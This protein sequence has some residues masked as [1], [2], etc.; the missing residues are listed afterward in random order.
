M[1]DQTS[2]PVAIIL[3]S[4]GSRGD[5]LLFRYP[6]IGPQTAENTV[7]KSV[8]NPYAVRLADDQQVEKKRPGSCL[9]K[10][11]L[12]GF[13]DDLLAAILATKSELCGQK[14]ELKINDLRFIGHPTLMH[15]GSKGQV[16]PKSEGPSMILFNIVFALKAAASI[17]VIQ[18]YHDFSKRLAIAL[19]HEEHRCGY[20][21]HEAK[22]MLG[23]VDEVAALPEADFDSQSP[24]SLMLNKSELARDLKHVYLSL[25]SNGDPEQ[26]NKCLEVLRPYHAMLLLDDAN[27][28]IAE[29]SPDMSPAL[30]RVFRVTTPLKSLRDLGADADL[31]LRQVFYLVSHLVYW[32]KATIIYPLCETNVYVLSPNASLQVNATLASRFVEHFPGMS[33]HAVM[34]DFSLPTQL[35]EQGNPLGLPHQQVQQV[36]TVVWMLQHRLL[37][38]LHTYVF[39]VPTSGPSSLL[40]KSRSTDTVGH[41]SQEELQEA[42]SRRISG[43]SNFS[44]TDSVASEYGSPQGSFV[45]SYSGLE[46]DMANM[47]AGLSVDL[48]E[49]R[50]PT[51]LKELLPDELSSEEKEAILSVPAA[52]SPEDF[53]MFARLCPYFQGCHHLEE[54][55]Y[56]ENV[57]RSTL[58]TLLDKFRSVLVTCQHEDRVTTV[59]HNL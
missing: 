42:D 20:L 33:L 1:D 9:S 32:A 46:S 19:R 35:R 21:S 51:R 14:F 15:Y 5:K 31:T 59:F 57:R 52:R 41:G 58:L 39:L 8:Q 6:Y 22:V 25:C 49:G 3:V 28:L 17:S 43:L 45:A 27:K 30:I 36:Q 54:I 53:K 11:H 26:I 7:K 12:F 29:L 55:M 48:D 10:G 34:E 24:F 23:V 38:Q 50:L 13:T 44:D 4:S 56:C 37:V 16:S 40:I 2:S 18:C 47:K